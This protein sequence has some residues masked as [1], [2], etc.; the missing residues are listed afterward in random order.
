M[1]VAVAS[2]VEVNCAKPVVDAAEAAEVAARAYMEAGP[3]V[4]VIVNVPPSIESAVSKASL[5]I[6]EHV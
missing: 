1:V 6:I 5:S 4:L 2:A 3:F